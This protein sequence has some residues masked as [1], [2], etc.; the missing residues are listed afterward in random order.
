MQLG[1]DS[2]HFMRRTGRVISKTPICSSNKGLES[3]PLNEVSAPCYKYA[4]M[5]NRV[6]VEED[7]I[8]ITASI[9]VNDCQE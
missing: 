2:S 5:V 7:E 3:L 8:G 4:L 6:S 1:F 9:G